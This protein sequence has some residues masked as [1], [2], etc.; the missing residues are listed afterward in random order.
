MHDEVMYRL[1]QPEL[2][3]RIGMGPFFAKMHFKDCDKSIR[4]ACSV[5]QKGIS[6]DF[7]GSLDRV[8]HVENDWSFSGAQ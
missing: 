8:I 6:E 2:T 5:L 7:I 1:N 4:L 3:D